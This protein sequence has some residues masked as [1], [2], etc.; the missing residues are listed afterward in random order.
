MN[1]VLSFVPSSPP[2]PKRLFGTGRLRYN[3]GSMKLCFTVTVLAYL[4]GSIPFGLILTR[5][6]LG[7]D[8]RQIGSGNIGATN[9]MRAGSKKLGLATLVLDAAKGYVAVKIALLLCHASFFGG[10]GDTPELMVAGL[11]ALGAI[12]GHIFPVWLKFKGGKGVATGLGVFLALE[13][14]AVGLALL[15]FIIVFLLFRY[16][17]LASIV[18]AAVFPLMA[19]LVLK[20]QV[21]PLMPFAAATSLL[22]IAKH[23]SNIRRLLGG[24]EHRLEAKKQ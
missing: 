8:V 2:P 18:A 9:V 1:Q 23:H 7:M 11:A 15:V 20:R 13:P 10:A 12:V 3:S 21:Y 6:F 14:R 5:V 19:A 24:T 16:V 17:S 4:L 22:I